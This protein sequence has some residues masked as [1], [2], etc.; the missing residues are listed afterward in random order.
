M[1]GVKSKAGS[2]LRDADFF[3]DPWGMVLDGFLGGFGWFFGVVLDC[4]W[5]VFGWGCF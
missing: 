3:E 5:L 2:L 4:F 1:A